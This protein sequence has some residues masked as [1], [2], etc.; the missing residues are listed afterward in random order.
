MG[1]RKPT[2]V[3]ALIEARKVA[4]DRVI[5]DNKRC[6][7]CRLRIEDAKVWLRGAVTHDWSMQYGGEPCQ[8]FT[9]LFQLQRLIQRQHQE[10]PTDRPAYRQLTTCHLPKLKFNSSVYRHYREQRS[11]LPS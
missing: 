10:S 3:Y 5:E 7:S 4:F 1:I 11:A 8:D 6:S 2:V 9:E